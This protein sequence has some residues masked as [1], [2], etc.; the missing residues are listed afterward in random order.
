MLR[1]R[2]LAAVLTVLGVVVALPA[3]ASGTAAAADQTLNWT[4]NDSIT[5][6]A[7]FPATAVAGATTIVFENSEATGNTTGMTHTLTFDTSTPGYNHDVSVNITASPFDSAGGRH[8]Q[9]VTLTPG[10]YR[11]FCAIP[12]HQM[13]GEFTVTGGGGEDTTPPTVTAALSGDQ[14]A[15]GNYVGS[16]TAT[17]TATDDA[18]GVDSVEYSLDGGAWTTYSAPVVV[19]TVGDH[20][21]HYRATDVAGNTSPEGMSDF[22]VV[23]GGGGD[24]TTPPTVSA[25]LSGDQDADGNYIGSATV[26]VTATDS[27]S[28]VA[29]V[30]YEVDD[31]GFQPYTGPVTV[32]T[33]GDHAVQYRATDAAGNA[34]PTGSTPFRV[35]EGGGDTTPPTVTAEVSGTQDADGN[36]VDAATVTLSAT[37]DASGVDSVEYS[38]DGAA[39]APYTAPVVV[40][41]AGAHML[42]YRATD[43]AG[44]VSPEG[45][46]DFTVVS[47]DTTAPTVSV[48]VTGSQDADG[49]YVGSAVVTV[50]AT[51]AG[52]GVASV[53]YALDGGAFAPYTGPV[54]VSAAGS[55]TFAFRATD[56]AGNVSEDGSVTFAVVAAPGDD[57]TPP[58]VSAVVS[59]NQ[60]ASWHYL[61]SATL[62]IDA[63][64]VDSGVASVEYTLDGGAWTA[65]TAPVTVDTAGTHTVTYRAT[66]H[67]GNVSAE[68]SGSFTIVE[69][70]DDACPS[71]DTRA[72]V[73]IGTNDTG[74][75]NV[76]TG[77]G[78]TINDLIAENAEYGTHNKFVNHVNQVTDQLVTDGVITSQQ[79]STIVNAAIDSDVGKRAKFA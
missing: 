24:D 41:A 37:D 25:A 73:V 18:S 47:V 77:N 45:M 50:T 65:Y 71:S 54:Q 64:D 49:N 31:T 48:A 7:S 46:A 70:T 16:A 6:Y 42:H 3:A 8:E 43:G 30:E 66:D 1:A 9:Q 27:E 10:K 4:A 15:D 58:S 57:T 19:D 72:T 33:P 63:L 38:L 79:R 55:H 53:E 74:V 14:D 36:Y 76:D 21:L 68:L 2:I 78:C 28:G 59:G 35:V 11:Y 5:A 62:T 22:T 61:D 56:V 39:F 12:G 17:L 69:T 44:N 20:M 52:S 75:P 67:A 60:D 23:S 13:T 40:N 29:T 32:S 34:S 26:T 51:D